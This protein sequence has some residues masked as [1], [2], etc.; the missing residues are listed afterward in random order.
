MNFPLKDRQA[1]GSGI[2]SRCVFIS[3]TTSDDWFPFAWVDRNT[4]R[5]LDTNPRN[6]P[7]W[8]SSASLK[9]CL[10]P[11]PWEYSII[12]DIIIN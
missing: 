8:G 6:E 7:L 9:L 12:I 4:S 1:N 10:Q 5:T 11:W 2:G 3:S